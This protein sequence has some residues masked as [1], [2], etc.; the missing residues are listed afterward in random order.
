MTGSHIKQ[1]LLRFYDS[2]VLRHAGISLALLCVLLGI[3][4]SG[5]QNFQLD[6]SS[7]SLVLENDAD[8]RYYRVV[9][10]R[11]GSDD[12][13]V[14]SYT[15]EQDMFSDATLQAIRTLRDELKI[16]PRVESVITLLDAPL[17]LSPPVSLFAM[18]RDYQTLEMESVDLELARKELTTSPLYGERLL[19][20]DGKTTAIQVNFKADTVQRR[21]L[22]ERDRLW[23][24]K[25]SRGLDA[26]EKQELA[27]LDE[28]IRQEN[29]RILQ[30]EE[31][32][33]AALRDIVVRHGGQAERFVGGI[34][35]I[36]VDMINFIQGDLL[37]FGVGVV[38]MMALTMAII[39]HRWRWV[40]LPTA[41]S[42]LT[43][44]V[45]TGV[46][47]LLDW[48]VTVISSNYFSLLLIMTLS[49]VIHLV[50]RYREL[51]HACLDMD[52]PVLIARTLRSMA[53]PCLFTTL[54]TVVA[55]GS[56]IVSGI[57]PVID[58]GW[59]MAIGTVLGLVL[60]FLAFP[61]IMSLLPSMDKEP[62]STRPPV[63][64]YFARLTDAYGNKILLV[65]V[66]ILI[67]ALL[68]L[69]RLGVENRFIDYFDE[70][71][72]IHQ[73]MKNIDARLGG[74]TPLE[75][76]VEGMGKAYWSD[77]VVRDQAAGIHKFL[78]D[79]PETGKVLSVDTI[80]RV[81][82]EVNVGI[83]LD[84]FYL[85]LMRRQMPD[86]VQRLVIAPYLS[87][88]H[89]QL[90]F[91]L[92][93]RESDPDLNRQALIETIRGHLVEDMGLAAERVH[94]S[95]MLVLYNNMLQSLFRSQIMT[96]GAVLLAV[97]L[98]FML[99]FGSL[100]LALIGI[101]PNII[102][103]AFILGAMGWFGIPLD[104]MTITIAAIAIGI[105]VDDTIHYVHRF[106]KEF[107]E[108]RDYLAAMYR[109]HA[110]IGRAMLYTSVI[111][112]AGFSV[113]S[114][115][116]FVP[117]VYFGLF[118]GFAMIA[119]LL[120]NLTVLPKLLVMLRPL[121]ERMAGMREV[122]QALFGWLGIGDSKRGGDD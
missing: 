5:I 111:I 47:G 38:L 26:M 60:T 50:V 102:P 43:G 88:Q 12:Y 46:L 33:V 74:T 67:F 45:M 27:T 64:S 24:K 77:P 72:E 29:S 25:Y 18:G 8:L 97:M 76:I 9:K 95:G 35:M 78:D 4:L 32:N 40:L 17:F 10:S 115:S 15:P 63:T 81:F 21:L 16:L 104:M 119:A 105:G 37:V 13:M 51:H 2:L 30:Q 118:T 106:Q 6:A 11:Y 84:N 85:S 80:M 83:P 62:A 20:A 92:R 61:M 53:R 112:T 34:Q 73:G 91:T 49:I 42:L 56:L 14:I 89:D 110:S 116:N 94:V 39:F 86:D 55:F 109:S 99:V 87:E 108:D 28:S 98:M 82:E 66:A 103:S 23:E 79:L 121:D 75:V 57:R 65:A 107:Q 59:M 120:A 22:K 70:N 117:T 96:I 114:L 113:L 122:S 69:P 41:L 19:S 54:T 48:R 68:G 100:R 93:V 31:E 44:V 71:T 7:D 90:R 3:A 52:K 58:F 101:I 36:V 1:A